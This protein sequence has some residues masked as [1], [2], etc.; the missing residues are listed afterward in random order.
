MKEQNPSPAPKQYMAFISYSHADNKEEGRK[1]ADWL[2]TSLETYEIPEELVGQK[3]SRGEEIPR[4][5]YPVFQDEKELS[6]SASLSDSLK[7]SLDRTEN[8]VLLCS[9]KSAKSIYV[10]DEVRYFKQIG[11]SKNIIALILSGE[12]QSIENENELQCFPKALRYAVNGD[13]EILMDQP[14]EPIAADVRTEDAAEGFTSP[15]AYRRRLLNKNLSKAELNARVAAYKEKLDNAKLKIISGILK[16][17]LGE[18]TKRDKAYELK[19]MKARNRNIK[20]VAT[21]IGILGI[22]AIILGVLAWRQKNKAEDT[23]ARS[24]YQTGVNHIESQDIAN[25]AA[26]ISAAARMGNKNAEM[27]AQSLLT[28]QSSEVKL[29]NLQYTNTLQYSPSGKFIVYVADNGVTK[30]QLNAWDAFNLKPLKILNN[31]K[32]STIFKPQ[33]GNETTVYAL[34]ENGNIV[35]WD[36]EKDMAEAVTNFDSTS[37]VLSFKLS[38]S[39]RMAYLNFV[40]RNAAFYNVDA[41]KIASK[42]F[43]LLNNGA[44]YNTVKFSTTGNYVVE[45][46]ANSAT[47]RLSAINGDSVLKME[48]ITL[49]SAVTDSKFNDRG[50]QLALY[51]NNKI[52]L[53]NLNQSHEPKLI[54]VPAS[55]TDVLFNP[56]GKSIVAKSSFNMN[57]FST[58][59]GSF[60][61]N[62]PRNRFIDNLFSDNKSLSPDRTQEAKMVNNEVFIQNVVSIPMLKSQIILDTTL[63]K[64][65]TSQTNENVYVLNKG[66]SQVEVYNLFTGEQQAPVF[67]TPERINAL[68]HSEKAKLFYTVSGPGSISNRLTIRFWDESTGKQASPNINLF[69]QGST[70][71]ISPDGKNF[72]ARVNEKTIGIYNIQSGKPDI[73]FTSKKEVRNYLISENLQNAIIVAPDKSWQVADVKNNKVIKEIPASDVS[74]VAGGFS[75]DGSKL[76]TRTSDG[77][78]SVYNVNNMSLSF[79]FPS[80]TTNEGVLKFSPDGKT[81]AASDNI[82]AIK[83]WDVE[84]KISF[85]QTIKSTQSINNFEWTKDG[86]Y[87]YVVL[88]DF[89]EGNI[90]V[91]DASTGYPAAQPFG[92]GVVLGSQ[93]IESNNSIMTLSVTNYNLQLN[94]WE[95]PGQLKLSKD[96]LASD[97]EILFGKKLNLTT[98]AIAAVTDSVRDNSRWY[99]QDPYIRK[100]TPGAQL[101]IIETIKEHVPVKNDA[102][103]NFLIASNKNPLT[104]AAVADYFSKDPTTGFIAAYLLELAKY[105]LPRI[106]DEGLKKEV[107]QIM[108]TTEQQL[109]K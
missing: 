67:K 83:L 6:A 72:A 48:T 52:Y 57:V 44:S 109:K 16:V 97:L 14:E 5:I 45:H 108:N 56:D 106:K 51:N 65:I 79:S 82:N 12:P 32:F 49:D 102:D 27:F 60:L 22:A 34:Q 62:I 69:K 9:P 91:Y 50:D 42:T 93:V 76:A 71:F 89:S 100:A 88:N 35:R 63:L 24:L 103:V 18:L 17:P 59:N 4:Q 96:Q 15:E 98:G 47:I 31:Y 84:D 26:Y 11:R 90:F 41:K 30:G 68:G 94:F 58:E 66:A 73:Q 53:I 21:A 105:Q 33:F 36:F 75:P 87:I 7:G 13:G 29:P 20:R 23:L 92:S 19:K 46:A 80:Q 78:V 40:N 55:F 70:F 2:H 3:N 104:R 64:A 99:F 61:K 39:G 1:W 85:G 28:N 38:P 43:P 86:K 8:L 107:T 74:I 95:M 77:T 101:A 81:L 10:Q 54:R 25:G 37:A